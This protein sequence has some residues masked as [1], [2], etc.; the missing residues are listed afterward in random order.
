MTESSPDVT[1]YRKE[2]VRVRRSIRAS[3]N[4]LSLWTS[5]TEEGVIEDADQ[6]DVQDM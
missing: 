2:T 5:A 4:G 6:P 3:A 1:A